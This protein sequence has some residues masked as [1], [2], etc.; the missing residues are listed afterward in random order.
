[1]DPTFALFDKFMVGLLEKFDEQLQ[2]LQCAQK[3]LEIENAN[4]KNEI[5]QLKNERYDLKTENTDL[6]IKIEEM[7]Q[8]HRQ[9][10]AADNNDLLKRI[11]ESHEKYTKLADDNAALENRNKTATECLEDVYNRIGVMFGNDVDRKNSYVDHIGI[12]Y[13]GGE[14]DTTSILSTI[15]EMDEEDSKLGMP[16]ADGPMNTGGNVCLEFKREWLRTPSPPPPTGPTRRQPTTVDGGTAIDFNTTFLSPDDVIVTGAYAGEKPL[17]C[18]TC[19]RRFNRKKNLDIHIC[20]QAAM[21]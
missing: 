21:K 5:S 14:S 18:T 19:G 9:L 16:G 12:E 4:Q 2:Q 1:M 8:M 11:D 3:Q 20:V 15:E 10:M 6:K 13:V 7:E 17:E